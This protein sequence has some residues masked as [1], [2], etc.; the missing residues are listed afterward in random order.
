MSQR[1]DCFVIFADMRTGSNFLEANLNALD[2]L[3]CHGEAFNP[4]FIGYPNKDDI[5][6]VTL[7]ER[8]A[9]PHALLQKIRQ[10]AD[11]SIGIYGQLFNADGSTRGGE[12][13]VNTYTLGHQQVSS[14]SM[15]DNGNFVVTWGSQNQDGSNY[16]VFA[17]M[18]DAN[19]NF[20]QFGVTSI[21]SGVTAT[22]SSE[23]GG[24]FD[25]LGH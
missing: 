9:D 11:G 2:C 15:D 7:D 10:N 19:G 22:A 8:V 12:F 4:H 1:F 13:L 17:Q 5:L 18:F 21:I 20:G 25:R 23:L 3:T 24:S 6:G 16:G 14:V